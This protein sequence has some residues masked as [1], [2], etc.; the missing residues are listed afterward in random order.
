MKVYI[1]QLLSKIVFVLFLLLLLFIL[2]LGANKKS[3]SQS[4]GFPVRLTIPVINVNAKIQQLGITPKGEMEVPINSV[5][6]GWYKLGP[7]PGKKG[8]AVIAGHFNGTNDEPGVFFNLYQLKKGDKIYVKDDRERTTTFVIR[9]NR[10]YDPGYA[11]D[12]FISNDNS[13]LNL[14]TCDGVWDGAKNSYSKRLVVFAD[15]AR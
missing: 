14:I 8:N 11:N 9:E 2:N 15:I 3:T 1:K 12:V 13:H 5:D 4:Q 10:I 6:V 7:R